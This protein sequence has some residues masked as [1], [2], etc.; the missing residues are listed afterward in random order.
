MF[1]YNLVFTYLPDSFLSSFSW[2]LWSM[3]SSCQLIPVTFR[4]CI[5][6]VQFAWS[7]ASCQKSLIHVQGLFGYYS[8][9]LSCIPSSFSSFKSKLIFSKCILNFPFS[10]EYPLNCLYCNLFVMRLILQWSLYF[11]AGS[12]ICQ[13]F[14]VTWVTSWSQIM[15]FLSLTFLIACST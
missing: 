11:V 9:H 5:N 3:Y 4:I 2:T 6:L 7:N 8:Q 10:P 12:F 15:A 13:A 14:I 1:G